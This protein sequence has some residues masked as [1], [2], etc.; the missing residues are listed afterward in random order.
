M[1][2]EVSG[3]GVMGPFKNIPI[4]EHHDHSILANPT[5]HALQ[6]LLK[7]LNMCTNL[8]VEHFD[9][10]K[11]VNFLGG[12][13]QVINNVLPLCHLHLGNFS[14]LLK[15]PHVSAVKRNLS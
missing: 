7:A 10:P 8:R 13:K 15:I 3:I 14:N 12:K 9:W 4:L 11:S 1:K 5:N 2:E 6:L